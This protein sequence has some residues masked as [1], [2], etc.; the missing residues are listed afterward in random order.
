[1]PRTS[2][3]LGAALI[4][5]ALLASSLGAADDTLKKGTPDLKSVGPLAFG[6][7]G[8]LFVG[9]PLGG[10]I[11]AIDTGDTAKEPATGA[12]KIEKID[13][14]IAAMLG[15]KPGELLV[16]SVA[17]NPSSGNVYL[18]VSRGRGPDAAP[19]LLRID[20]KG[21]IEEFA[22]KDVKF[23]K[24]TLPDAVQAGK[25]R[26]EAITGLAFL[27]GR[28]LVAGL[29]NEEFSSRLRSIPYP[30]K[31]T[32]K[33]SAVEIFHASHGKFETNSPVRTFV[34]YTIKG[35]D[36][37]LAAYTCTPLV[38]FP[39]SQ[40]KPGEKIKGTTIA[41][42]GNRN[43]PL[44]MIVYEKGGKDFILMANNSRGLMKIPTEG[45]EKIE[46]LVKPVKDK[47]G[48][49]YETIDALKGVQKLAKLDKDNAVVLIRAEGGALNLETV[50]LP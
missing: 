12:V 48:L 37:I 50:P 39:V 18:S 47:A 35:E 44:D 24:A 9:D 8:V 45:I 34:P 13:E 7:D 33:G 16:N 3:F 20:R 14:K 30:F 2:R 4:G 43:R 26:S 5:A 28:V 25:Q 40:L 23:A 21:K 22:I 42:L 41:E 6:P 36:H 29:T 1:M 31:D 17:V 11:F 38:K 27:K 15:T 49:T 46:G 19:V 10:A 32:E